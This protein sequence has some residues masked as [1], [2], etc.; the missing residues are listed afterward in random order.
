MQRAKRGANFDT[1]IFQ[2][3]FTHLIAVNALR[4]HH[5]QHVVHLVLQ[6]AKGLQPHRLNAFQQRIAV[7]LVPGDAVVQPFLEDQPRAFAG[8]KQR[9]GGF[10]VMVQPLRPPVIHHHAEIEIVGVDHLLVAVAMGVGAD[11]L[12]DA[13]AA[14]DRLFHA[15]AQGDR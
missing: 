15:W 2:H 3:Q 11:P 12:L 10:S 6:I 4:D 13:F 8:A 1:E 7:Q 9:G 5:A 14:A